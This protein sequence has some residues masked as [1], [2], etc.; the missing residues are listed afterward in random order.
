MGREIR[1]LARRKIQNQ[2]LHLTFKTYSTDNK[3]SESRLSAD[4]SMSYFYPRLIG[5]TRSAEMFFTGRNIY[6]HEAERIG[7]VY[8]VFPD[9]EFYERVRIC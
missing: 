2:T 4:A 6:A 3:I 8:S 5:H 9:E 7:L 1:S